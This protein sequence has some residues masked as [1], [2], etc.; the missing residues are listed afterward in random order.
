V[1]LGNC[2]WRSAM[3]DG[4]Y[5]NKAKCPRYRRLQVHRFKRAVFQARPISQKR[6]GPSSIRGTPCSS[7]DAAWQNLAARKPTAPRQSEANSQALMDFILPFLVS[8]AANPP[9]VSTVS[10]DLSS[11]RAAS[12]LQ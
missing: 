5:S 7:V 8:N 4:E 2:N 11:E 6:R 9:E 1:C 10:P 3:A 12:P